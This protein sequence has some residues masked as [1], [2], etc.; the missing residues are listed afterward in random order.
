[1]ECDA[2]E[3]SWKFTDVSC[4]L[5]FILFLFIYLFILKS[6]GSVN[7]QN[8]HKSREDRAVSRLRKR[9]VFLVTTASGVNKVQQ[10]VGCSRRTFA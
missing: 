5:L 10:P 6:V 3:V 9:K 2:V 8:I 4:H 1:V 7:L